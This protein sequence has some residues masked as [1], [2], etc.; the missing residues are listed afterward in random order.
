LACGIPI[1]EVYAHINNGLDRVS[2]ANWQ[3]HQMAQAALK[4]SLKKLSKLASG[5]QRASKSSTME[6]GP[7]GPERIEETYTS[8]DLEAAKAL[9]KFAIDA[10]KLARTGA[11]A[12]K[13]DGQPD[14]FDEPAAENP[15]DLKKPE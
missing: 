3:L 6:M 13:T 11:G 1:D 15:W 14:L 8:D 7:L 5:E 9:A 4:K 10:L 2:A 12:K